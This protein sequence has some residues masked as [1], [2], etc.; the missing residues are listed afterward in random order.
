AWTVDH[1]AGGEFVGDAVRVRQ[2]LLNLV[3]NAVKFTD[4]G[5]VRVSVTAVD[6]QSAGTG[7]QHTVRM[8]VAD[9]GI[10]ISE[11]D[12]KA[13]FSEFAQTDE[14]LKR[15]SGGTGLGLAISQ[16]LAKVMGGDLKIESINGS[17]SSFVVDLKLQPV[18]GVSMTRRGAPALPRTKLAVLL[19]F[20]RAL[21]RAALKDILADSGID[22]VECALE[23]AAHASQ[24]AAA[25]GTPFTRVIV[26]SEADPDLAKAVLDA[27]V[28][29]GVKTGLS[30]SDVRGLV[31]VSMLS[32]DTLPEFQEQGF[33]AYLVRPVRPKALL[34][35][36]I[37]QRCSISGRWGK[38]KDAPTSRPNSTVPEKLRF[39]LVEDNDINA[40]LVE[41]QLVRLGHKVVRACDGQ[42]AVAEMQ[43]AICNA[44]LTFDVVLM[45]VLLPVMDGFEATA[46]IHALFEEH[47]AKVKRPPIIA[48]TANAFEEDRQ[49]CLKAGMDD[50]LAKPFDQ[51]MLE[52]VLCRCFQPDMQV[53]DSESWSI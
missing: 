31:L 1:L 50:Y 41:H 44:E 49:H 39:L 38:Q 13:L 4:K 27:V 30:Q 2:I 5:G 23:D 18:S 16:R 36:L 6:T 33:D 3:S 24:A 15:Q 12:Q 40:M 46:A 45:D 53:S 29:A 52:T 21:E 22:V 37:T 28:R 14:A 25:N 35:Q 20:D 32:R 51:G 11:E 7:S 34:E 48:L 26:D 8:C 43:N 19:A 10:G 17:G 9:T 47:G 42:E